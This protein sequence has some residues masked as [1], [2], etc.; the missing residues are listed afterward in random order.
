MTSQIFS[1][2]TAVFKFQNCISQSTLG[3]MNWSTNFFLRVLLT[4]SLECYMQRLD[5]RP[6]MKCLVMV[7][8][9]QI[10]RENV[11]LLNLQLLFIICI[12]ELI[13]NVP[14]L[15][16]QIVCTC[17]LSHM[18]NCV[19]SHDRTWKWEISKVSRVARRWSWS[20]R[21]ATIPW[22]AGQQEWVVIWLDPSVVL[23]T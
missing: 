9:F 12:H 4:S 23:L 15:L 20:G 22:R 6:I 1:C 19:L 16:K 8:M 5:R 13:V 2:S 10:P 11:S 21:L 3:I 18:G 7:R 14:L 17:F